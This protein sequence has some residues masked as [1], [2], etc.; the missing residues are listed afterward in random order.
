M[1]AAVSPTWSGL[2]DDVSAAGGPGP[3]VDLHART[4]AHGTALAGEAGALLGRT[5]VPDDVLPLLRGYTHPLHVVLT[6]GAGAVMGPMGLATKLGLTVAGLELVLRDVDDPA[7]NVRRVVAAV[8]AARAE[9]VLD[10]DVPVH[11]EIPVADPSAGWGQPS[12][13]WLQAADEA[14]NAELRLTLRLGGTHRDRFSTPAALVSMIDAA[15]DRETPFRITGATT[16]AVTTQVEVADGP[17]TA[18]GAANVLLATRRTF[19]GVG[20]DEVLA[21]LAETDPGVLGEQVAGE[22]FLAATRRW[23]TGWGATSGTSAADLL[24]T[25]AADLTRLGQLG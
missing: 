3:D 10:E 9:G 14:A 7:G 25:A 13:L 4:A 16:H 24:A 20:R 2:L 19:D 15:L 12:G 5:V 21:T 11:V 6:G 23:L 18:F 22:E 1:S 8:D 17:A